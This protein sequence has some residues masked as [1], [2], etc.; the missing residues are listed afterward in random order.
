MPNQTASTVSVAGASG[1]LDARHGLSSDARLSSL[2]LRA[3]MPSPSFA[4]RPAPKGSPMGP[5]ANRTDER[6]RRI[7]P[8]L[9][10][11]WR[12]LF[13]AESRRQRHESGS[14]LALSL[15]SS[16]PLHY[17]PVARLATSPAAAGAPGGGAPTT[18]GGGSC[19]G[20]ECEIGAVREHRARRSERFG[21][22][23]RRRPAPAR[24]AV[25][26]R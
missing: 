26:T 3:R 19:A 25:R 22:G 16:Q 17:D 4:R 18:G 5:V 6:E 21:R 12:P 10:A 8:L 14:A 1:F 13:A 23:R 11:A 2:L 15:L 7:C 9:L 20:R 24:P